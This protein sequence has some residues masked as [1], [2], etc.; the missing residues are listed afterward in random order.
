[1][2]ADPAGAQP[3]R[4]A[5]DG[6]LA[7]LEIFLVFLKLGLTS[8]GGPIAHLGYLRHEFVVRRHWLGEA[9]Y[10]AIVAM[11]HTL[12]GPTSTQVGMTLGLRRA[13]WAGCLVA[14]VAFTLP[15]AFIM[16]SLGCWTARAR[17]NLNADLVHG[18]SLV[19]VVI[20]AQALIGMA[21]SLCPD[22]PR[23]L[24]ALAVASVALFWTSPV[25]QLG[26][27]L[28]SGGLGFLFIAP[29]RPLETD[30]R[31]TGRAGAGLWAIG[32]LILLLVVLPIAAV[33]WPLAELR[34]FNTYFRLGALVFGGGHV[35]LALLQSS[36]VD[37]GL[38]S[39][40]LFRAGYGAAQALPG[41][42]FTIAGFLGSAANEP[43]NGV[44][45]G[46]IA[47][48]A[49]FAPSFLLV[50][51]APPLWDFLQ[52]ARG[53]HRAL[54]GLNAGVVGLL[55]AAWINPLLVQSIAQPWDGVIAL[56]G[57]LALIGWRWPPLAIVVLIVAVCLARAA[58]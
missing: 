27:M 16:I 35:V 11:C 31:P 5:A 57:A 37:A 18:F 14:W 21:T 36:I 40:G 58:L 51:A 12:P 46:L 42:L 48:L 38:V 30:P 25:G 47:I 9:S 20:V 26:L 45:G 49:I 24:I 56:C 15:S 8:F 34:E 4:S 2:A 32:L 3:D 10:A 6:P 23:R 39:D 54:A 33:S 7:L 17:H 19:A 55:L 44:W 13:G 22:A 50:L 43:P 28:L 41:P 52:R 1:M 29:E 53:M